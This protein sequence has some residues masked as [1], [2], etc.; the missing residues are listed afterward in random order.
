VE[1]A[2]PPWSLLSVTMIAFFLPVGGAIVTVLN[3]RRMNI[4]DA[5]QARQLVIAVVT[6]CALGL[7]VLLAAAD[8]RTG[9]VPQIDSTAESVLSVGVALSSY[10]AQRGPYL[11]W[12]G[13]DGPRPTSPWLRAAGTA[14]LF[15]LLTAVIMFPM[16][17]VASLFV[18]PHGSGL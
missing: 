16:W 8:R 15:T 6:L 18:S 9:A 13:T 11:Q 17:L 4:L 3:L 14:L 1:S 10:L 2:R 12:R 7:A 5:R